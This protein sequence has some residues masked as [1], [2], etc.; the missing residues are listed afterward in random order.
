MKA[1]EPQYQQIV[2]HPD[3]LAIYQESE[4]RVKKHR[5]IF[6]QLIADEARVYP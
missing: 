5:D 1:T 4:K 3:W 6:L 2:N